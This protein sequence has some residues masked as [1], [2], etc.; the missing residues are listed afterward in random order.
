MES[1]LWP[2]RGQVLKR[3]ARGADWRTA[4]RSVYPSGSFG[5]GAA[6]RAPVMGLFYSGRPDEFE[7]AV[8]LS[9]EVTHTHPLGIEGRSLL[10]TATRAA[11]EG[12]PPVEILEESASAARLEPFAVRLDVARRWLKSAPD[13]RPPGR[14][15]ELGNRIS[16]QESVVTALY[17]AFRFW[18]APVPRPDPVCHGG[19][20]AM[21]TRSRPWRARMESRARPRSSFPPDRWPG[22]RTRRDL[23]SRRGSARATRDHRLSS[24]SDGWAVTGPRAGRQPRR[25]RGSRRRS[26]PGRPRSGSRSSPP[27]SP[28][29]APAA[30]PRRG[31]P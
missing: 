19:S 8:R 12:R 23:G 20:G 22:W 4:N 27:R 10:A 18:N 17:L 13:A 3:I 31:R 11:L 15:A 24:C 1:R 29:S 9:A 7:A 30:S 14:C 2:R 21:S 16:A 25:G 6:M 5:N 26:P 28:R